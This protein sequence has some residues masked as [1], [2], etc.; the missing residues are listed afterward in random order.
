MR[1]RDLV[2]FGTRPAERE[3][4]R[5]LEVLVERTAGPESFAQ[6]LVDL[7]PD[8]QITGPL[9]IRGVEI[10]EEYNELMSS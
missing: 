2:G 8:N 4:V 9:Y 6:S 3:Y 5:R 10:R 1:I 7:G